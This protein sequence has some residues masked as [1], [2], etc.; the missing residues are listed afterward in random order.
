MPDDELKRLIDYA[1]YAPVGIVTAV[2]EALPKAV[3]TGRAVVES[4][5]VM[6]RF[7]G[8]MAVDFASAKAKSE[9]DEIRAQVTNAVTSVL[10]EPWGDLARFIFGESGEESEADRTGGASGRR[11]SESGLDDDANAGTSQVQL[12]DVVAEAVPTPDIG[13]G[14]V[15]SVIPNYATL[16]AT[17]IV[18][19]L[20]LLKA[21][22]LA[23][24]IGFESGHR[25]RKTIIAKAEKLIGSNS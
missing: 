2:V 21:E 23:L 12:A 17:Q 10:P 11:N 6:A 22:E 15:E 13:V 3:E 8:K 19:R 18:K 9:V 24:I 14:A 25:G 7:I 16:S 20:D 1:V 4:R 5:T